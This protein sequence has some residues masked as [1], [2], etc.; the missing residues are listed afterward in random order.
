MRTTLNWVNTESELETLISY[1]KET[2]YACIDFETLD[3]KYYEDYSI[4]LMLGVSFQPGNTWIIPL[5][6]HESPFKGEWE[7]I[8]QK[9]GKGVMSDP[10][11]TKIAW[12]AKYEY[13]WFKSSKVRIMGRFFDGM[14]A[15]YLLNEER[16][17]DL[18]SMVARF[19]PD[20]AGYEKELGEKSGRDWGK[21]P[22]GTMGTY[23]GIDCDAT[24]RLMLQFEKKC[25]D[26]GFYMLF[27]NMNMMLTRVLGTTE[28]QGMHLDM[29][30]LNDL[31]L[32]YD[33]KIED[34]LIILNSHPFV[35]K[36]DKAR[37]K[38]KKKAMIR[39]LKDEIIALS[40]NIPIVDKKKVAA[41]QKQIATRKQKVSNIINNVFT[42]KK[43]LEAFEPFN[44]ASPNQMIE[45]LFNSKYGF[46]FDI[47]KY[48]VDKKT[49]KETQRPSTDESV[50]VE[51]AKQDDSG[52]L[53]T[54]LDYRGLTKLHSTNIVGILA[55][56]S[57]DGWI[58]TNY[59]IH[60]TVTCRLSSET[61][62]LQNIPRVTTNADI[63]RM[64]TPPDGFLHMELDYSQAELRVVAEMS[65]DKNMVQMFQE[66]YSIH[67]ATAAKMAN[68]D[69]KE[70]RDM[71][72]DESHPRHDWANKMKKKAKTYNF[73][74]LYGQSAKKLAETITNATKEV[75]TVEEAQQGLDDW[76]KSFPGIKKWIAKQHAF[77]K[78]NGY[79]YNP[80]GFKRRLPDVYS[81]MFGKQLEAMR[82]SVNAPIQGAASYFTLF[83]AI[84]IWEKI[85]LGEF[86]AYMDLRYTVHD[87]LGFYV[88]AE[89]IHW[90]VPKLI[91]ICSNPQTQ[92]FFGFQ[93][94]KVKMKAECEIG[95]HWADLHEYDK[96]LDYTT[97]LNK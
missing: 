18:K 57:D 47:V 94:E 41:I 46:Q 96:N 81:S 35:L 8:L 36:Y 71:T 84:I 43:D 82:Q 92:E 85:R 86:P 89:D 5:G 73:G 20:F 7:R 6:H 53:E 59:K 28:F 70:L 55:E 60:G 26:N 45:L 49:K 12:N 97:W 27:R 21:I 69:Y 79:V 4:P 62:N 80:F 37:L 9:F 1:C 29:E 95:R 22:M 48:T 83:S 39:V 74:I 16:P 42:T 13:K 58:H 93:F 76:F 67:V 31:K 75:C 88:K 11:I 90:L 63:K 33:K 61:P 10:K 34:A 40:A 24:F 38:T 3:L 52:F 30:Y 56:A 51:L 23:C 19:L 44:F 15:K 77:V 25:I 14:L 66:G 91:E 50:L 64:F 72:K 2:G 68:M 78:E 54:M 65:G 32:R 87:S 17:N